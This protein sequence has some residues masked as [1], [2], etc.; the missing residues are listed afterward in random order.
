MLA[1]H[2]GAVELNSNGFARIA[3]REGGILDAHATVLD[4]TEL[5]IDEGAKALLS[6]SQDGS[7]LSEPH[8]VRD[9][10]V[11]GT[12]EIEGPFD[13]D[14]F[15]SLTGP[16]TIL[17]ASS[18]NLT[19]EL[20]ISDPD[21]T[22]GTLN[23]SGRTVQPTWSLTPNGTD[24][25]VSIVRGISGD[26]NLDGIVNFADFLIVSSNLNQP[27][28]NG[29]L[30]GD[31]SGAGVTSFSDFLALSDNFGRTGFRS[32]GAA[33]VPEPSAFVVLLIGF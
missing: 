6:I 24:L 17:Q 32:A 2:E 8:R 19:G 13:S 28:E 21:G 18:A 20:E 3:V 11:D 7:M 1:V 29:W 25:N 33:A 22:L 16:L 30:D 12:V 10:S 31:F 26:A 14:A 9:L 5:S 15:L 23:M 4:V 27:S